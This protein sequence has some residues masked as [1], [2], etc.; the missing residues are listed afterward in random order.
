MANKSNVNSL[1]SQL[2]RPKN[3]AQLTGGNTTITN[4]VVPLS[5][6]GSSARASALNRLSDTK[7]SG[8]NGPVEAKSIQFGS[9]SST[10]FSS[11]TTGSSWGTLLNQFASGG[12]ANALGNSLGSIGGLGSLVSGIISLFGGSKQAPPALV[13]FQLPASQTETAYIGSQSRSV[14]QGA[15]S[16]QSIRSTTPPIYASSRTSKNSNASPAITYDT[17]AITQAVKQ[18]LLNS[19]SL[20]DVIAEI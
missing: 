16:E 19:S 10:K 3:G 6:G 18:A 17:A 7:A 4:L 11:T 5:S 8:I 13:R 1:L 9:P 15:A 14:L 2:S 12:A 20:N